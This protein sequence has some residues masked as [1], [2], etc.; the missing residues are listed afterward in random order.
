M[1]MPTQND[2]FTKGTNV[3]GENVQMRLCSKPIKVAEDIYGKLGYKKM[4]F[5]KI[6]LCSTQ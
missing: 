5:R 3:L 2:V 4:P 6:Q 1:R